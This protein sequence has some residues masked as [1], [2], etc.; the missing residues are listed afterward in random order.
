[1]LQNTVPRYATSVFHKKNFGPD[2]KKYAP[3]PKKIQLPELKI[4][5][6]A[7]SR[8][9]NIIKPTATQA[10]VI[11]KTAPAATSLTTLICGFRSGQ[12]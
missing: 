5:N 12:T 6:N 2:A 4:Q 11:R 9:K 8:G 7:K 10:K 3:G 1:M